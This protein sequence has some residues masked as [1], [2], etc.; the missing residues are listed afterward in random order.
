MN[1]NSAEP[2]DIYHV[3][4]CTHTRYRLFVH[5][6]PFF[7][8]REALGRP[9]TAATEVRTQ[10]QHEHITGLKYQRLL[11]S[12]FG[13]LIISFYRTRRVV[14]TLINVILKKT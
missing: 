13:R 2:R 10:E 1:T 8:S 14:N 7:T 6:D 12:S 9:H 11:L 5:R 3:A 4:V